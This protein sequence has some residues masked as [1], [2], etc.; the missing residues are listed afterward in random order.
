MTINKDTWC[1][2]M[3]GDRSQDNRDH[4]AEY[5]SL[6]PDSTT[7]Y[8]SDLKIVTVTTIILFLHL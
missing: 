1:I 3:W 6:N 2:I 4:E 7:Y 5:S 8:L